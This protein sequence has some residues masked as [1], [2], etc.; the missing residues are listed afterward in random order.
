MKIRLTTT[1][2]LKQGLRL[3]FGITLTNFFVTTTIPLK[4]GLRLRKVGV[5]TISGIDH[6]YST[7]TRIKTI[8]HFAP[9]IP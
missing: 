6:Y 7:K 4:Q 2:P 1:I 5:I 9:T 8:E 3:D